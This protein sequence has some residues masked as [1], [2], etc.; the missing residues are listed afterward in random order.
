MVKSGPINGE[1]SKSEMML[2]I[3][4]EMEFISWG[5]RTMFEIKSENC[6]AWFHWQNMMMI[7]FLTLFKRVQTLSSTNNTN[8]RQT[9]F[10]R[11]RDDNIL[12]D[13]RSF[14]I[15]GVSKP[16][17]WLKMWSF[18]INRV[19]KNLE[20]QWVFRTRFEIKNVKLFHPWGFKDYHV[21][22]YLTMKVEL[23]AFKSMG[24]QNQVWY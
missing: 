7:Y 13:T 3:V 5:F 12:F 21:D 24:F 19:W 4:G 20:H 18:Y 11:V 16:G 15:N 10:Q 22:E 14:Y 9:L 23:E 17:L 6:W 1:K 8:N 2:Y